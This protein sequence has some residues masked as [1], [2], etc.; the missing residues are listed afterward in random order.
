M[1]DELHKA[2]YGTNAGEPMQK[3]LV[4][5]NTHL[6]VPMPPVAPPRAP[7]QAIPSEPLGTG[8]DTPRERVPASR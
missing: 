7:E 1:S 8:A 6:V 3:S 2:C 4:L 5:P